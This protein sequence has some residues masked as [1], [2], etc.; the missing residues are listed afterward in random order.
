MNAMTSLLAAPA[1]QP[2]ACVTEYR[3]VTNRVRRHSARI[4]ATQRHRYQ[5]WLLRNE[6]P[7]PAAIGTR[8]QKESDTLERNED[9]NGTASE[10]MLR[11]RQEALRTR[12]G[13]RPGRS[14]R[15]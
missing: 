6:K 8:R 5:S 7:P 10:A 9:P 13:R 15:P 1:M 3:Q 11:R 4:K 2:P 14:C 12:R